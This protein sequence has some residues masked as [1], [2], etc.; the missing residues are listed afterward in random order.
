M[1]RAGVLASVYSD[2]D[3]IVTHLAGFISEF[4][5]T[6]LLPKPQ[7]PRYFQ[8]KINDSVARSLNVVVDEPTRVFSR[9]PDTR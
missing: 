9:K 1:V 8:V 3:D 5:S 6:G 7:Y 2:V 4:E